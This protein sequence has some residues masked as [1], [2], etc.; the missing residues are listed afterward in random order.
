LTKGVQYTTFRLSHGG[1]FDQ[2]GSLIFC[3]YFSR[4]FLL[5]LLNSKLIKYFMKVFINHSVNSQVGSIEDM[6][7]SPFV[8]ADLSWNY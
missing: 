1:V 8:K 3:D 6:Y 5:G 7:C 4:E 2:K